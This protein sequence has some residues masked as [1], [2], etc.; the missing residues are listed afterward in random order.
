[1]TSS[2]AKSLALIDTVA[3]LI[4]TF[5]ALVRRH[6]PGW[7]PF[8]IVDQSLLRNTIRDGHLTA[9]TVRRVAGYVWSA[10]DA[11]ADADSGDLLLDWRRRRCSATALCGAAGARR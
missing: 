10:A 6:L 5:E 4:P 11:G 9:G 2:S 3:E 1:M 7:Q 8:N